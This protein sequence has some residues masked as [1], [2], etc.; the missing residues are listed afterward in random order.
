MFSAG[1]TYTHTQ[2]DC[3]VNWY[4]TQDTVCKPGGSRTVIQ[5]LP[6]PVIV[7]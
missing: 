2:G 6:A 1:C 5:V 3:V 4:I 7:E